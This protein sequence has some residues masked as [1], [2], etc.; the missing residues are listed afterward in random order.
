[1][2]ADGDDTTLEQ[3]LDCILP[4]GMSV[5]SSTVLLL[6]LSLIVV[7]VVLVLLAVFLL[8]VT[9]VVIFAVVV[10]VFVI[11]D[12]GDGDVGGCSGVTLINLVFS[13]I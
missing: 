9:A 8:A 4:P 6:V 3:Y 7:A 12:G 1:M 2:P 11:V 13:F 5:F 10:V